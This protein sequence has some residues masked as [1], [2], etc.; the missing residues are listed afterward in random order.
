MRNEFSSL[1]IIYFL[2]FDYYPN[3]KTR[4]GEINALP[5]EITNIMVFTWQFHKR[6]NI[7]VQLLSSG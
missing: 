7:F 2:D 6:R 5:D 3:E 4:I 1:M